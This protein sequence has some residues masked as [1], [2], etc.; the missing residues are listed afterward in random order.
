MP[1]EPG[2]AML[3]STLLESEQSRRKS[4]GGTQHERRRSARGFCPSRDH[5]RWC[6]QA[7][8]RRWLGTGGG[9]H[10]REGGDHAAP[11]PVSPV[12]LGCR[13]Y[14]LHCPPP[15]SGRGRRGG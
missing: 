10:E 4:Y 12:G 9:C 8:V 7:G 11:P 1:D 2:R 6:R 15:L 14:F 3:C 13:V 5:A